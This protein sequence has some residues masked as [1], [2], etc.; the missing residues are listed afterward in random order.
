MSYTVKFRF[1]ANYADQFQ[2][3]SSVHCVVNSQ[4]PLQGFL[5]SLHV[6]GLTQ[7]MNLPV[8]DGIQLTKV[9]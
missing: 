3:V 9:D 1:K 5:Y 2:P 8:I 6:T 4:W 7:I